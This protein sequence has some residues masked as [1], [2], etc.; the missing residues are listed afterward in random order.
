MLASS[1]GEPVHRRLFNFSFRSFRK[2]IS[3]RW[4]SIN[5]LR[6]IFYHPPSTEF[7][8][9]IERLICEQAQFQL[10]SI[11]IQFNTHCRLILFFFRC[12]YKFVK[13]LQIEN[14]DLPG[15]N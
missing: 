15:Y 11:G 8:E 1:T 6:F 14:Y 10:K 3:L 12:W 7:E 4:R 13:L 9:K 2:H 5:P